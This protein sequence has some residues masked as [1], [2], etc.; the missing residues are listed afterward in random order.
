MR[1]PGLVDDAEGILADGPDGTVMLALDLHSK[2]LISVRWPA[3]TDSRKS[4]HTRPTIWDGNPSNQGPAGGNR[5]SRARRRRKFRRW[6]APG[7]NSPAP[8]HPGWRRWWPGS[9]RCDPGCGA[10]P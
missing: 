10:R 5:Y 2:T 9:G 8:A 1:Q 7:R 4:A 3:S 6:W